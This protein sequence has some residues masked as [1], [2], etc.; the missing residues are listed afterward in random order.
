M[1]GLA[2]VFYFF[3]GFNLLKVLWFVGIVPAPPY[4]LETTICLAPIGMRGR[5]LG[6]HPLLFLTPH[7]IVGAFLLILFGL[8]LENRHQGFE[9][10]Y[11]ITS[12]VWCIHM[13]PERETLPSRL[14]PYFNQVV[15]VPLFILSIVGLFPIADKGWLWIACVCLIALA[16]FIDGLQALVNIVNRFR[17]GK[18]SIPEGDEPGPRNL[19]GYAGCP[20]A[21]G[22]KKNGGEGELSQL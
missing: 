18:F 20:F 12:I 13:W 11:F 6:S 19:A 15:I 9:Y 1:L 8:Y 4:G 22:V 5:K 21:C 3:A 10:V 17:T 7:T 2:I 14:I 16:P